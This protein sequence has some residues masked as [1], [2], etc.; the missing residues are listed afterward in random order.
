MIRVEGGC[1]VATEMV[2]DD[3][4]PWIAFTRLDDAGWTEGSEEVRPLPT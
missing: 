2:G 1:L 3:G 4:V